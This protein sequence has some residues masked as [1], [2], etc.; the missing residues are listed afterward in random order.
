ME[1]AMPSLGPASALLL[2]VFYGI[3]SARQ[4]MEHLDYNLLYRCFVGLDADAAV[5]A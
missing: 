4:L 3:R 1:A 5:W 2:Q